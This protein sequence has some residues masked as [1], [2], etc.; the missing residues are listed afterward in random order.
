MGWHGVLCHCTHN[1]HLRVYG[2]DAERLTV[3]HEHLARPA[4]PKTKLELVCRIPRPPWCVFLF[5]MP[6]NQRTEE[7]ACCRL[8]V[9]GAC[10]ACNIESLELGGP[11]PL[12]MAVSGAVAACCPHMATL[13]V[14]HELNVHNTSSQGE[15]EAASAAHAAGL[16]SLLTLCGPRLGKLEVASSAHQWPAQCCAALQHC[17]S[18]HSLKLTARWAGTT[19]VGGDAPGEQSEGTH[20]VSSRRGRT[21]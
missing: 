1:W 9:L 16:V 17:T 8:A 11:F 13:K 14:H 3:Y 18:L 21:R 4:P 12:T 10:S 5:V 2:N 6:L 15:A 7:P 19:S 20:Q